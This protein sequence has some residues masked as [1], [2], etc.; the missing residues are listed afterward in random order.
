MQQKDEKGMGTTGKI[1][2]IAGCAAIAGYFGMS[3][4]G[5]ISQDTQ[6]YTK[7]SEQEGYQ[8]HCDVRPPTSGFWASNWIRPFSDKDG[9]AVVSFSDSNGLA[10]IIYDF[11]NNGRLDISEK[12]EVMEPNAKGK[13]G[14]VTYLDGKVIDS[15]EKSVYSNGSLSVQNRILK[16]AADIR[17]KWAG[18][19]SRSEFGKK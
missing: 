11:N 5:R 7:N 13:M 1:I 17:N 15:D 16:E 3:A 4:Y 9:T 6:G 8:V 10:A 2:L 14:K 19:Y 12:L 18:I